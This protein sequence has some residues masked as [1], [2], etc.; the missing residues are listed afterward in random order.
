MKNLEHIQQV[1]LF[2]WATLN[3]F[4]YPQ[5]ELMYAI[6]NGGQRS[7]T[8]AVKLKAEGVKAGMPDI[9]LPIQKSFINSNGDLRFW[10]ALYIELKVKPNKPTDV[11][12]KKM[13][14]LEMYENKCVV[15]YSWQ[16]AADEIVKYL[17][18]GN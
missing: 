2:K 10:N 15:C 8:T 11:Q 7:I 18:K 6:P 9:C 3:L 4:K 12:V 13:K 14:L 16:E 5:L 17:Q 1:N